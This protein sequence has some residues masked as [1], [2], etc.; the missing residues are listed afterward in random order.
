[1]PWSRQR[2][3]TTNM[4]E[5]LNIPGVKPQS[6]PERLFFIG[7]LV[8]EWMALANGTKKHFQSQKGSVTL[9][10]DKTDDIIQ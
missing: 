10:H 5:R 4:P 3:L 2:V 6:D 8:S 9:L 7:A 1:M